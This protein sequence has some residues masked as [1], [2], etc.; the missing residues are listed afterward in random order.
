MSNNSKTVQDLYLQWRTNRKSYIVHR[1]AP[2]SINLDD[3]WPK[4]SRSRH[5]LTLNISEMVRDTDIVILKYYSS[6]TFRVT[7]SDLAKYTVTRNDIARSLC[8]SWASCY[9]RLN[10][11]YIWTVRQVRYTEDSFIEQVGL[12]CHDECI[13]VV[14]RNKNDHIKD[15]LVA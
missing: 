1:T 5:Y 4:T 6:V 14:D 15:E 12:H 3:P 11:A 9:F 13:P 10:F 7:L 8:D 2:F